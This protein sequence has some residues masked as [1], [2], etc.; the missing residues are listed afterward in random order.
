ML[1]ETSQKYPSVLMI[2]VENNDL[3]TTGHLFIFNKSTFCLQVVR[4]S[5]P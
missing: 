1:Y 5:K 4:V 2:N 3:F